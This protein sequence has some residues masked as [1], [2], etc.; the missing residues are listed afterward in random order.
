VGVLKTAGCLSHRSGE[1]SA[2]M[3][4]ELAFHETAWHCRA[5]QLDI[6]TA[7]SKA[8]LMNGLGYNFL[9]GA[10]FTLN[11]DNRIGSSDHVQ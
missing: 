3:A 10:G 1:C 8:L 2:L 9:A 11:K 6:W 7:L 4:E 5:V